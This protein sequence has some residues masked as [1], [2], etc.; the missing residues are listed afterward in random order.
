[1]SSTAFSP[2][3]IDIA[4]N[5]NQVLAGGT[6]ST[7]LSASGPPN[8]P[9]CNATRSNAVTVTPTFTYSGGAVCQPIAATTFNAC[10]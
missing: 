7:T 9:D 10:R 3:D 1:M 8:P 5:P 4:A 2:T 6:T